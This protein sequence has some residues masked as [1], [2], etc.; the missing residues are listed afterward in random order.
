MRSKN[1]SS[2]RDSLKL[3][4]TAAIGLSAINFI[5]CKNKEYEIERNGDFQTNQINYLTNLHH[6]MS[7]GIRVKGYFHWS[8]MDN[9]EWVF[10]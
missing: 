10:G 6:A 5:G 8:L 3:G 1:C 4:G 9:F 7:E 2:R